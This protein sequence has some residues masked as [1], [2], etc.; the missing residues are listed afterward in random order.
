[1]F[2]AYNR[3]HKPVLAYNVAGDISQ[4]R[5]QLPGSE[6]LQSQDMP[7]CT[8]NT[9]LRHFWCQSLINQPRYCKGSTSCD[10]TAC[11]QSTLLSR[12]NKDQIACERWAPISGFCTARTARMEAIVVLHPHFVDFARFELNW[13]ILV[14][15]VKCMLYGSIATRHHSCCV[16]PTNT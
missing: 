8:N 13:N 2:F 3:L 14:W 4:I 7:A 6:T 12:K 1:M 16:A 11:A 10:H 9:S 15:D 5:D